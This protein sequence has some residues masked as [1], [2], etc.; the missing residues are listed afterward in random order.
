VTEALPEAALKDLSYHG[1]NLA[2]ARRSYPD[3]PEPWIDLSTGVNPWAYPLPPFAQEDWTRLP[4]PADLAALEATAARRYGA[5]ADQTIAAPGTQAII[6]LLARL[7]KA[8][9]VGMLG[10]SYSGHAHAWRGAGAAVEIVESLEELAAFDVAIVVNPN[11]PD[12]RLS[13]SARLLSLHA[14]LAEQGRILI[15]DE[16]FMD[17][18]RRGQSLAARLPQ[19]HVVVLRSFGKTY[20]LAGVRLGFAIA[21]ADLAVLLR[22]GLGSWP[23]SGPAIRIGRVALADDGWPEEARLRLEGEAAR[24]DRLLRRYGFEISGGT[25]LFRLVRHR[26]AAHVFESLAQGGILVRPFPESPGQLRLGIPREWESWLRL[27]ARLATL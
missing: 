26:R 17:L 9:R 24:L 23:V 4:A 11:N 16:A 15:V 2:A 3:A 7:R 18:D 10:V 21:S 27:Q 1:G 12:G 5:A 19:S 25:T 6:Q 22:G 14:R 8:K 20:G 13:E